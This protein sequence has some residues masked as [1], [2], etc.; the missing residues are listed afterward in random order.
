[1]GKPEWK[2]Q[3]RALF[4]GAIRTMLIHPPFEEKTKSMKTNKFFNLFT[5]LTLF[6]VVL[7]AC[8]TAATPAPAEPTEP[9]AAVETEAPAPAKTEAPAAE[10]TEAPAATEAPATT[11]EVT[12]EASGKKV[13][14]VA[15]TS[16][17][18]I[19]NA[20]TSQNLTDIELTM[21]EGL[22]VSNEKNTYIPVLAKEIPTATTARST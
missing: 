16:E 7:S 21:V 5:L 22:I 4:W 6:A 11:A 15:Y 10:V 17:I 9:P 1:M 3:N 20:L 14:R 2:A 18:D 8:T 19:L 12:V 13:L